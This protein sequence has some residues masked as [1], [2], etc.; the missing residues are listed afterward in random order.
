MEGDSLAVLGGWLVFFCGVPTP[1]GGFEG[2]SKTG[3]R[4][5][6]WLQADPADPLFT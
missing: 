3:L 4:N 5:L 2:K 6:D 1:F